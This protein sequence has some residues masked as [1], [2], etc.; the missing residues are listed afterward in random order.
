MLQ[1]KHLD[2][3]IADRK[4]SKALVLR[5][6][7]VFVVLAM[8]GTGSWFVWQIYNNQQLAKE[9]S[10][11]LAHVRL[12]SID[13]RIT[14]TGTIRPYNQVKLSPKFTGLLKTLSVQQGQYVKSGDVVAIMDDSN[15]RGQYDAARAAYLSAKAAYEK[16][17]HGSRPQELADS[18]AQLQKARQAVHAATMAVNHTKADIKAGEAQVVRD[19]TNAKRLTDLKNQG[20]IS[21]QDRLNAV[22]LAEVSKAQLQRTR[23]DLK[24]V[25]DQLDQAKSDYTSAQQ[26][27]SM[28]KEG[29]RK[30]DVSVA[31]QAVMQAQGNMLYVQSQLND[32]V[33]R[34]PFDGVVTQKYADS[35][36]IVTPTTA[37]TNNSATSSSI[38]SLAGRLEMVAAVAESD[39]DNI[40]PGQTA[41]I[42]ASAYPTKVFHGTVT[43]IAPE[44]IVNQNVTSFEV[45]TSIDD[46][47]DHKLMSGMN[48][49]CDFIAGK[50]DN[51]LL[52]PTVSVV[53]KRGKTGVFVPGKNNQ[54]EFKQVKIGTTSD[55]DTIVTSGLKEG[56][57][58]F[59]ALTKEQLNEQ[60]YTEKN[61]FGPPGGQNKPD[62][63]RGLKNKL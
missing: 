14:S 50:R 23:E 24:Q 61:M 55:T 6:C 18:E 16:A 39:I 58:I 11:N 52:I 31:E 13:I 4:F 2:L 19:E 47:K 30:E 59:M 45:H 9:A 54:P 44:A 38:I 60:G 46:D 63:P 17:L 28:V 51:V 42:T 49:N 12:G 57:S 1:E 37:S 40:Q 22:T 10:K 7:A 33:I 48:V 8:I 26:R 34:A 36:A 20:A 53:T 56:D 21:D 25:M 27:F 29:M 35:G 43:L 32:T 3:V 5:G 62:V 41:A 15:L